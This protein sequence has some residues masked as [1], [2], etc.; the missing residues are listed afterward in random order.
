[1]N[2]ADLANPLIDTANRRYFFFS[3]AC[4]PFGMV[5]LSPDTVPEGAWT[6]GYRY[7]VPFAAWFSHVHGWQMAGIPILPTTGFMRGPEGSE[8]YHSHFSH[9]TEV[10]QPG[11][12]RLELERYRI[13]AE[14]TATTRVGFH[15]YTFAE[16]DT[17]YILLDLGA[18]IGQSEIAEFS[19]EKKGDRAFD[20]WVEN[21]PT[22]RRPKPLR[23]YFVIES[24]S[25]IEE[26][27]GW[28]AEGGSLSGERITVARDGDEGTAGGGAY[29]KLPV[30]K[31]EQLLLKVA[32]SFTGVEGARKNMDAEAANRDFDSVRKEAWREWPEVLGGIE[33]SGGTHAQ[34]V[35]FYT[36]LYHALCGRR[37]VCDVDG[38][39]IDNTGE[40]PRVRSVPSDGEG[41]PVYEHHSTDGFWGAHWTINVLWPLLYPRA[42]W[43]FCNTFMSVY[44]D[45]GLVPRGIAGGNYS[46]VMVGAGSTSLLVSAIQKNIGTYDLEEVYEALRKN[47]MPGGLMSKSG[48]EHRTCVGG[49][50]EYYMERG[51]I[52]ERIEA[53]GIHRD[54]AGMTLEYAYY[55]WCLAQ[56]AKKLGK[57]DDYETL[58][59]RA[60]NYRNVYDAESGFMR[61][62]DFDGSFIP[63]FDPFSK[64]GFV[65]ANGWQSLWQVP[66][67]P[68]GLAELM[69]GPRIFAQR[70]DEQ[71]ERASESGFVAPAS[72]HWQVYINYGNQP[73]THM[74]HL[75]NYVGAPWL[76]QRWVRRVYETAKSDITPQGGYG[77]DE[78][79][80]LMGSLNA[81]MAIGLFSMRGGCEEDPVYEIT[82]PVFECVVIHLDPKYYPDADKPFVIEAPGASGS[83][84]Y[85]RSAE[86]NGRTLNGP[87]FRHSELAKGG[88]LRIY[89]GEEPNTLWGADPGDV[90]PSMIHG[91]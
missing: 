24:V 17:A 34:Q 14:L 55:D 57:K 1:M 48:Y 37:R 75:F 81:F 19:I 4:R 70:L 72:K 46:F 67:D 80:G 84:R 53:D 59:K 39:Y 13:S 78:D 12:H 60:G 8:A 71:F 68:M 54:G 87:W 10:V 2:P 15:R 79:Q 62:R 90:P 16:E 89:L 6:G 42:T 44:R 23:I 51:Y 43:N 73:S 76:T 91:L 9:R 88:T 7:N 36:D 38:S 11:Y 86:L 20:G 45:G 66:Q 63:D 83:M 58:M 25:D 85:I 41:K 5:N 47:H 26:L 33:V 35:K 18:E 21:A 32:I 82:A 3:S 40:K 56:L 31:G 29:F 64:F 65:E 77:G 22:R 52:P 49:G 28:D 74:A 61:P 30:G 69:G 27:G 50:L